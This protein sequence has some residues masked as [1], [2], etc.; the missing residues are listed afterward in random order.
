MTDDG[1]AIVGALLDQ[2][3]FVAAARAMFD[4]P[5]LA[6]CVEGKPFLAATAGGPDFG[7]GAFLAGEW[8]A[9]RGLAVAW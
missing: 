6:G 9:R 8:I 4:F 5:K 3:E 1:P 2:V 7:Q